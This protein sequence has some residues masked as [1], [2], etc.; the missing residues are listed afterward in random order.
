MAVR[1]DGPLIESQEV[2][3]LAEPLRRPIRLAVLISGGGSSLANLL[4]CRDAG[5]LDAEFPLVIASRSDCVGLQIAR[6]ARIRSEV[7]SRKSFKD[8]EEFSAQIF[9]LIRKARVDLV[10][11]AG[12]LCLVRIPPDFANRV[13]N[14][15]P[16]LIPSFCGKGLYGMKV[17][18]AVLARGAKV[19]GC[20]VHFADNLYDHGPIIVQKTVPVLEEDT[21]QMLAARVFKA[22]CQAYPD[23][24]RLFAAA[25]LVVTESRVRIDD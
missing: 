12:Y 11:L 3:P 23:A 16:A 22:E 20:T 17:H 2:R 10:V 6:N 4:K 14:I 9:A 7:V 15:H 5:L 25:R 19:S 8:T 18:E 24:I 21:P 1:E 13:M